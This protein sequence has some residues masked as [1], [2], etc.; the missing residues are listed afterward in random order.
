VQI[1]VS[2]VNES[3]RKSDL[4]SV[5][6]EPGA[7]NSIEANHEPAGVTP[8]ET[9]AEIKD[10]TDVP[11]LPDTDSKA[12]VQESRTAFS[13]V[14]QERTVAGYKLPETVVLTPL[15]EGI[16]VKETEPATSVS[17]PADAG[18]KPQDLKEIVVT[19]YPGPEKR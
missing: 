15:A 4:N 3:N 19:G 13:A 2:S 1:R 9:S 12:G 14:R 10:F 7:V 16:K 8:A 11:V 5:R 6:T 17:E 18:N